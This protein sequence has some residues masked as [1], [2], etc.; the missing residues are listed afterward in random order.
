MVRFP[1]PL[2]GYGRRRAVLIAVVAIAAWAAPIHAQSTVR[3]TVDSTLVTVGD[4][5]TL[6]VAVEHAPDATVAWPDS[7]D[8][9][10]FEVV[11]ARALGSEPSGGRVRSS[12]QFYL[13]AFQLGDLEIPDFE[14][15]VLG[16]G[17][18]RE[19]LRTDRFGIEV[20]SVG[21]DEGGDIREI[22]GPFLIP[23]GTITLLL[24]LLGLLAILGAAA[25]GYR[26]WRA[27]RG[28]VTVEAAAPARPAHE[29]ALE[30]LA[31]IEASRMLSRG[32]VKEYHIAVSET[33]RRYIEA[34]YRVPA[35]EMTTWEIVAGLEKVGVGRDFTGDLRRLLDQCD[36][37]KFAKVRPASDQAEGILVLGRELVEASISWMPD[38]GID[39]AATA[40]DTVDEAAGARDTVDEAAVAGPEVD[41][42]AAGPSPASV[43]EAP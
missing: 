25:Y 29:I 2:N 10:P 42:P 36:L 39:E 24:W 16:A 18:E 5:I 15:A 7:L 9:S 12:A 33:L 27:S 3:T 40:Q 11:G 43:G 22:R 38:D 37:V 21:A 26:R 1:G 20:V 30:A 6:T 34:R 35:L 41:G 32:Q 13:T 17:G 4:R 23:I 31:D 28:E 14:V 8:L 19:V